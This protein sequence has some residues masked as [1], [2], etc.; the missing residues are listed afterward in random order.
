ME[1]SLNKG[2][3]VFLSENGVA[4]CADEARINGDHNAQFSDVEVVFIQIYFFIPI[5]VC[6]LIGLA[7]Q[8]ENKFLFI[9]IC[10]AIS[11]VAISL[12]FWLMILKQFPTDRIHENTPWPLQFIFARL[13]PL[14][15]VYSRENGEHGQRVWLACPDEK[16]WG[17]NQRVTFEG[18]PVKTWAIAAHYLNSKKGNTISLYELNKELNNG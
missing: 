13:K 15:V 4:Y 12:T 11:E 18:K 5:F 7:T 16:C 17:I 1:K 2:D 14:T 10:S 3:V 8:S 9:A 6:G